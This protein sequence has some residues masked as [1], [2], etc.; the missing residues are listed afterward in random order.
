MLDRR[1]KGC[2]NIH[3]IHAKYEEREKEREK[4]NVD[5]ERERVKEGERQRETRRIM[6]QKFMCEKE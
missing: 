5:W 4:E 6:K 3:Q 1:M 2:H